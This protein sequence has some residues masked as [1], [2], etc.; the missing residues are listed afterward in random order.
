[1][2]QNRIEM[3]RALRGYSW[4]KEGWCL[5]LAAALEGVGPAEAAWQPPGN[6]TTIWQNVNHINYWNDY[7]LKRMTSQEVPT[8]FPPNSE[9]FGD[10]GNPADEA[11]WQET[12]ALTHRLA[13]GLQAHL[14]QL[15]DADLDVSLGK[16][17]VGA[18]LTSWVMHDTYHTGQIVLLRK[19][20]ESWPAKRD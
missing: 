1:M 10:P 18:S 4:E 3:L 16:Q 20:Q 7:L 9:T 8:T 19:M 6:G 5:P 17:T 2:I 14:A 13:E 11:G 12:L 15:T